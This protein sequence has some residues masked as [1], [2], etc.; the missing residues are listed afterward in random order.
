M[1]Q[2]ERFITPYEGWVST[3]FMDSGMVALVRQELEKIPASPEFIQSRRLCQFLSHVVEQKLT[4]GEDRLKES[5][6]GVEVFGRAPDYDP[7]N[8]PILRT[9]ARRLRQKLDQ[10]Y[11][12]VGDG[13][14][15]IRICLPTGSY[16]PVFEG[17]GEGPVDPGES[18]TVG[19][20]VT[21]PERGWFLGKSA[22]F[23]GIVGALSLLLVVGGVV[24]MAVSPRQIFGW[25]QLGAVEPSIVNVT[26][27]MGRQGRPTFWP[28]G[29]E[30]AYQSYGEQDKRGEIHLVM[31]TGGESR[32]LTSGQDSDGSPA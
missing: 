12:R 23:G 6:I 2:P 15:R 5:V 10:Y 27:H 17:V 9:E 18:E 25:M 20:T 28:D 29:S 1:I 31:A 32:R 4:G 24:T 30:L 3:E 11:A 8:N 13:G 7:K 22:R 16:V 21:A 19:G 26:S 14:Y